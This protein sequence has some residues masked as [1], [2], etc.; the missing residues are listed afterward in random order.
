MSSM[1][2]LLVVLG[3]ELQVASDHTVHVMDGALDTGD[4]A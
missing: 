3:A 1:S 2:S 4:V